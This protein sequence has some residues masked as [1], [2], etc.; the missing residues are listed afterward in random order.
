[1]SRIWPIAVAVQGLDHRPII[2]LA[3][4]LGVQLRVI[5]DGI[6]VR[7]SR[8]GFQVGRG[9]EVAD[10]EFVQVGHDAGRVAERQFPWLKLEAV[11]RRGVTA[12]AADRLRDG[13]EQPIG[14]KRRGRSWPP[15]A[16]VEDQQFVG[17]HLLAVASG[18]VRILPDR[19]LPP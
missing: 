8:A 7:A 15:S 18:R 19:R 14:P 2:V 17:K 9:V 13:I 6:A 1:M 5:D 10:A 4:Q 12:T 3:A 11:G 16:A